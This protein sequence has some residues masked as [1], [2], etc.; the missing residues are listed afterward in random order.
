MVMLLSVT[1]IYAEPGEGLAPETLAQVAE[2]TVTPETLGVTEDLS[3]SF[4]EM[5]KSVVVIRHINGEGHGTGF[6]VANDMVVTNHHV[7]QEN[8]YLHTM[9]GVKQIHIG[10]YQHVMVEDHTGVKAIGEV[11]KSNQADDWAVIKLL[12]SK[13][14]SKPVRLSDD[15]AERG[16]KIHMIGH[17]AQFMYTYS[18]GYVANIKQGDEVKGRRFLASL[19]ATM[20]SSGSPVWNDKGEV[21]GMLSEI[22]RMGGGSLIVPLE[23]FKDELK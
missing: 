21:I 19:M 2:V 13:L 14:N 11:V 7:V 5:K 17:P 23:V 15:W 1:T 12:N 9:F 4:D 3:F 8:T 22:S 10:Q 6:M 18:T 16:E 20:G